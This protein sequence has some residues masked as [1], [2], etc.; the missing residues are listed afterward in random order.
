MVVQSSYTDD[1]M[2]VYNPQ[3]GNEML[4]IESATPAE[5]AGVLPPNT[6]VRSANFFIN[7]AAEA[8][9]RDRS[10]ELRVGKRRRRL[11]AAEMARTTT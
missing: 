5:P 7:P 9:Q 6:N 4:V 10:V 3:D 8:L 1:A 2:T 11:A